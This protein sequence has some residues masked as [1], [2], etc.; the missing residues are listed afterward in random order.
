MDS[1]E[2]YVEKIT[3]R[4]EDSGYT[5]LTISSESGE[6]C[7][8]G[9]FPSISEG[10]YIEVEGALTVHPTYGPQIK[11]ERYSFVAPRDQ[12]AILRYLSS[13]AVKGI[14][15]KLAKRVVAVF[16]DETFRIL[17]EEPERL[18]EVKGISER[19]AMSIAEQ[20]VEKREARNAVLFLQQYGISL[21]NAA[22]IYKRYG[23]DLYRILRE[24]PYRLCEDIA[25]IG[26]KAADEIALKM[27]IASDS[28]FRISAAVLYVLSAASANG[29][30][31][32]PRDMV[33]AETE[34]LLGLNL[35]D[36]DHILEGLLVERRI[37]LEKDGTDLRVYLR[38]MY[39]LEQNTAIMLS[40]LNINDPSG[41]NEAALRKIKSI[42][43][44]LQVEL[45]VRQREAILAADKNGVS[46]LT[47]GP[48]TGKTTAINVMIYYFIEK[49]L[50]LMLAAPTGRAAKRMTEATGFEAQTIH[51]MLEVNGNPEDK[52][53]R[54]LFNRN[55]DHPLEADVIIVDETSMVDIT[56]MHA[57]LKACVPG[58]R[59]IFVGDEDQLPSV[60][61]GEVLKDLIHSGCFPVTK[62]TKIFRQAEESDIIVNAHK[63]NEGEVVEPKRSND[64][65]FVLR[66]DPGQTI[67]ATITL[68]RDKLPKYVGAST[69]EL[70]VLTPMRKG[71]FGVENLNRILQ[72]A[73]NPPAEGKPERKYG[74][75]VFR[76]GDKVMQTRNN[77]EL[78]WHTE[79]MVPEK[80]GMGI[81]N[82]DIGFIRE[83]NGF[84]QT[85]R[86]EFDDRRFVDYPFAAL[87]DL[88]L[89]Y[90]ITVH[91]SQGSE[92]PAVVLPLF[93]GP[94]ML[95][96]RNLL[97][98]GVTRAR[99]CVCI[100][101]RFDTFA[102]MIKNARVTRRYSG[103]REKILKAHESY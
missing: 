78:E 47:G 31:Y 24:N 87:E 100:V 85:L 48:G 70:Q 92:Y 83:I 77:Y 1:F 90:A 41:G 54:L 60:G 67:G 7:V 94:E 76:L 39:Q 79:G 89:S 61:P 74:D 97:Y 56:L 42:E 10:E 21:N 84:T 73:F 98:T 34:A 103:L 69:E 12:V 20:V 64:F 59:L 16:G 81:F 53:V 11:M 57:L 4:S 32:L 14:G 23:G 50:N 25:G 86:I 6:H 99:K 96:S 22:K 88:E 71:P 63:I 80:R 46:V 2:G 75:S 26:F 101:G 15:E 51:R 19:T 93:G 45:D 62:L 102:R 33:F 43:K 28:D 36:F 82:G 38:S 40:R 29:H 91:K 9:T 8:V 49:G 72:E 68:L 17:E 27:N 3:Y 35:S 55:D 37:A 44:S 58:M 18:A 95:M 30:T 52:D 65:L 13:G 66:E 5:V